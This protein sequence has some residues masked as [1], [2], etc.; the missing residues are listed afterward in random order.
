[1]S[2]PAAIVKTWRVGRYTAQV[3]VKRP[4]EDG[5]AQRVVVEWL[6]G[7]PRALTDRDYA[8][9]RAARNRAIAEIAA[10]LGINAA[11]LEL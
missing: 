8:T 3:T 9:H 5:V 4:A 7:P 1:M 10:E 2:G 11:V 6:P